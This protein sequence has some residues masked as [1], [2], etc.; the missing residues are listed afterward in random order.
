[1]NSKKEKIF[2]NSKR[3]FLFGRFALGL[4][5]TGFLL[6]YPSFN[7]LA[8]DGLM[9]GKFL[10]GET[11]DYLFWLQTY[12]S[13]TSPYYFDKFYINKAGNVGIGTTGPGYTL[14]VNGSINVASGSFYKYNGINLAYSQTA[15]NNYYF[16]ES[17]NL[18]G[19]GL[20]NTALGYRAL[21]NNT[22]GNQN[23]PIG[24][25][26]LYNNT[27]GN[28]NMAM[29]YYSLF[30]NTTGG[31]NV[32]LGSGSGYNGS[33]PLQ[34]MS[35]STFIGN[36]A[37][38]SVD[39]ITN[40]T[41]IGNGATVTASNQMV[42]G[43]SSVTQT[44][45]NGNVGIGTTAPG[46]KLDVSGTL[47]NTLAT[48]HSLLG[49]A[50]NAVVMADNTGTLYNTALSTFIS[51]NTLWGGTRNGNIW[52]GDAGVGNVGIGTTSPGA[53]LDVAGEIRITADG[54]G[55]ASNVAQIYTDA[56]NGLVITGHAGT[57]YDWAIADG[58]GTFQLVNPQGTSNLALVP[59]A[60]NVGIGTTAPGNKLQVQSFSNV[61][62]LSAENGVA[63]IGDAVSNV[64]LEIGSHN[65]APF[66]VWLQSK[67]PSNDGAFPL[68]LNPLGGN[69]G[70]GTVLPGAL[71]DV[72]GKVRV[73]GVNGLATANLNIQGNNVAGEEQLVIGNT[74]T[75]HWGA[76]F[77]STGNTDAFV[78]NNYNSDSARFDIRMK[79]TALADAKVTVLGSGNV[80]IGTTA[81][82]T[83]L[84]VSG[85]F[86]NTLAT[87]HSL[88]GGVGNAVV[89]AD[90]TGTL[91]NTALSTFISSNTLWGG[92]RNGNI[93][94]G[95]AGA[96]NVGIGTT[97]PTVK[98][99]VA[100]NSDANTNIANFLNGGQSTV[101][102]YTWISFGKS[103]ASG[104]AASFGFVEDTATPANSWA[105]FGTP[106]G[107]S[108]ATKSLIVA[109]SGNVGIGTTNPAQQLE[110]TKNFRI[111]STS[112][113]TPYGIIYKGT[114]PFIHDFNYGNNG[115][116][117][118]AGYNTF[119]GL[120][121]GNLTMGSTAT[122]TYHSSYNTAVGY[123]ALSSNTTGNYNTA[124]GYRSLYYN[125]TGF[126]NTANGM[127]SLYYN[128]TGYSNTANGF[129]SLYSN[130]TGYFNTAN[131]YLSLYS[132]TTGYNNTAL[133]LNSGRYIADGATGR[134]T[135][136]SGLY[137]G[138][139][140]K[141]SADGTD[142]EIV[143]G[144]SA[145]GK[146]T[147]TATYGN[148]SMTKHIFESGNVGIGTTG[149]GAKLDVSGTL[150]N[151]LATT[152]S[153]LGGVGNAVVMADNTGT[154]YNTALSTFISS[155]TLWGGTRNGNIWNGDAG[156]GN[157]GIGTT[158]PSY[159][160]DLGSPYTGIIGN[161]RLNGASSNL[162]REG[163]FEM[164][165]TI[166]GI[167]GISCWGGDAAVPSVINGDVPDGLN[168]IQYAQTHSSGGCQLWVNKNLIKV[169]PNQTYT[170]SFWAKLISGTVNSG[171]LMYIQS[172]DA[173]QS[174]I[175]ATGVYAGGNIST[176]WKRYSHS[177]TTGATTNYVRLFGYNYNTGVAQFD[178]VSFQKGDVSSEY[179]LSDSELAPD[180]V[181]Q[182][183]LFVNGNVGIGTTA[184]V[185]KLD[186]I[187]TTADADGEMRIG[188][189][190]NSDNLPFG[191]INFANTNAANT[192]T[193]DILSSIS[194]Y[195]KGSSNRGSIL[196]KTNEGSGLVDRMIVDEYGNVGIGTTAPGTKLDVSGTLRN[197]LATT[198]S[199]LGG[200]GNAVVM[201]DNTGTLYNTA[202]STFIS[203]NTLWGGTR[204]GNIWNG[205]AGVGNVGIGTTNPT[206]KL[207]VTGAIR[208]TGAITSEGG[209]NIGTGGGYNLLSYTG[210][211]FNI[212]GINDL[213]NSVALKTNQSTRL[214]IALAGNVGIGTTAPQTKLTIEDTSGT[215]RMRLNNGQNSWSVSNQNLGAFP[216]NSI[217]TFDVSGSYSPK[218]AIDASGNVGIGT[219]NPAQKLHVIGNGII[220]G[221]DGN[222]LS[223]RGN[224]ETSGLL[225]SSSASGYKEIQ[226]FESEPLYINRQGNN[227]ILN[228]TAGNVGIGTTAPGTK[229]DVTGTLR[230]TLATTHS[231]LGGV[232]NAVVMADNTG[233]LYN[234]AL[235]TFISSNTLWSGT[236]NGNIWNGD[237]GVGNVGIGTTSPTAPLH[238]KSDVATVISASTLDDTGMSGMR[239]SNYDTTA[240]AGGLLSFQ[241]GSSGTSWAGIGA[242]RPSADNSELAFFT[243]S[244]SVGERM[245]IT[246]T[247]NVG[248][249]TTNPAQQLEIT[250]NFRMPSTSG[251]TPYGIIYKGTTPFIHDFN[252]GNNGT[253]TTAGYNTFVG[254]GAGNLT[255]GSTATSA[256][257]SS[258]NTAVGYGALSS[259]TTGNYNTA[260]GYRSLYYNTTGFQNTANGMHSLNYNTTGHYN[261]ANGMYSLFYNTTGN[262][263]TANGY[264]S[265][266]SNTTGANNTALGF[267][268]ARYIADGATGRTTGN[269]GLYLGYDSK[270]SADGTDNEIVIGYNAI[271]KGSNTAT[272]GNTSMTKHI[273]ESG[274]VGIG[275]TTPGT[276]L[277]LDGTTENIVDVTG[278]K[279]VGLNTTPTGASEAVPLTYLQSNY[280]PLGSGAGSAYVQGGN[281]FGTTATLG[282][283]DNNLLN[284]ETNNAVRMTVAAGGNVG[285]GTTNPNSLLDVSA[286]ISGKA[287]LTLQADTDNNNEL[288]NP[289]IHF[290]QD[291][292]LVTGTLGLVGGNNL[293]SMGSAYTGASDNG[294][295]IASYHSSY[296]LQLG[297]GSAV[298]MTIA[299]NGNIGIGTTGPTHKLEVVGDI[300]AGTGV[301]DFK[302]TGVPAT[303]GNFN[304]GQTSGSGKINFVSN[305]DISLVTI[306]NNGNV[307]IGTTT[308][309]TKLTLDGTTGNIVDVTGG[310][311]VGLNTTPTGASE[312]VPLT[313]LQSNYTPIGSGAG[314]IG[315]G[316]T[317]QTLRHNGTS[318]IANSVIFNNGTNVGI[319][320][321]AP[322]RLL[323]VNGT[324]HAVGL[325][326][327][328]SNLVFTQ[329][330]SARNIGVVGT[331]SPNSLAAIWSMGAA[332]QLTATGTAGNLYG[333][334]YSYEPDYGG[335]GNNPGAIA[336][337]EHQIQW[338]ANGVTKTAI[339]TG[340]YTVGNVS[341]AGTTGLTLS[342]AGADLNFTGTGPNLVNTASGVNLALMPGGAGNVGIGTTAPSQKMHV[343]GNIKTSGD[344]ITDGNYGLG[345]VGLYSATRYQNVFA[346]GTSYRLA[347]DGTTPGNLYGIAWTHS[348]ISGQS[349]SGLAHQALFMNNGVTQTAIGTGIWTLGGYTQNGTS[350]NSFSGNV[351]IGT[352]SPGTKLSITGAYP[353][354]QI[355][356]VEDEGLFFAGASAASHYNWLIGEQ[357][358]VSSALEITPSTVVGGTTFS[359]PT[360]VFTQTGNV[361]IGTTI[362]VSRLNISE[363]TG[364]VYGAVQGSV[365]IDHENSGG[366]SSIVF[367]SRVNRGSD[368]GFIQ[369]QDTATVGGAGETAKL[370]IGTSNDTNDDIALMPTGNV[371]I[372]TTNPTAKLDF[373]TSGAASNVI[374]TY[375]SGNIIQGIGND[376]YGM[377]IFYPSSSAGNLAIGTV[378]TADGV[379]WSEK[380]R[381][382]NL[383][384][385]GIG[386]TN[387]LEK[388][389]V[390]GASNATD[391]EWAAA[392][393]NPNNTISG[394]Y[395]VGLKLRNGDVSEPGK[396]SGIAAVAESG[397]SNLTGLALYAN[398]TEKVRIMNNGNVGIGTTNPG[399][400]LEI[401][402]GVRE[403]SLSGNS[404]LDIV[405]TAIASRTTN[406]VQNLLRLHQPN[407]ALSDS[408]G[409]T[410]AI[411]ISFPDDPGNNYPRTRVDFKTTGRTTDDAD[412]GNTVMSLMDSGNVG[413]GTTAPGTGVTMTGG[414]DVNGT[415]ST[416]FIVRKNGGFGLALNVNANYSW[417]MYDGYGSSWK[418]GIT[419]QN[420]NVGIG[421]TNPASK[422]EVLGT[423]TVSTVA[424]DGLGM[425]KAGTFDPPYTIDGVKY[426]TYL[427]SMTGV[428]EETTGTTKLVGIGKSGLYKKRL[429]MLEATPGSDLWLFSRVTDIKN[430]GLDDLTVLLSP[431]FEGTTWYEKD[432]A[433]GAITIYARPKGQNII[434]EVS[435]RLTAPR[436][437]NGEFKNQRSVYDP[438]EGFNLDK[439]IK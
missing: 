173:S 422:L 218:M 406:T 28:Q 340:I 359:T 236:R 305:A 230:N 317:G 75:Y 390:Q 255:M 69:V 385:V 411:G 356:S 224:T 194:G 7:A 147:N 135:G 281:S 51:S 221:N 349:K 107:N 208:T 22:T 438:V 314:G 111:P 373:G 57:T 100:S 178:G 23:N 372:G 160:L 129:L 400:S 334:N 310:R 79:G 80:G 368:Y 324:F 304:I 70:I 272:Y 13:A 110:I 298:R 439:L 225:L 106:Y 66:G 329:S 149:P 249:G 309:G 148:T 201:A 171:N 89:M 251:T 3:F 183:S 353:Q 128:T 24:Y 97:A 244:G 226:S 60:G 191:T 91:Y 116:V 252:Y 327:L 423:L 274:N 15:L 158:N 250:K 282:T 266:Y 215:V 273:F 206:Y 424:G 307:G 90:N 8:I 32:A 140:S 76:G 336:G 217:L 120:G 267:Y 39:G 141:A 83:K 72:A 331:Y 143:I 427:P 63:I 395:G 297:A 126:N 162:F 38:S 270:A 220:G 335:A 292:A 306:L 200:V 53:K 253:V 179:A 300:Y 346:M 19:T 86:R 428:K 295:L 375:T 358:N 125:T 114:T 31:Y 404:V 103:L 437:D 401:A 357:Y 389:Y 20:Q 9:N 188:G 54:G 394:S 113:T 195:K 196:F 181:A 237:A 354:I 388:L 41:A 133:G 187:E 320:T 408:K 278:G 379:T 210:S 269:N 362:P 176:T 348:N 392:L 118:T 279:I 78:S 2:L 416:Q 155:N 132:N 363:A 315:T 144:A 239:I 351:G 163:S 50:G 301:G 43:N 58:G 166:Y 48:T 165:G 333:L 425:I 47:R 46:T 18:T 172:Y 56:T 42:F 40:S 276:K 414:L 318:W 4:V 101:G 383:G 150:R 84:D 71:L 376:G 131:G 185:K 193:D 96:G 29:G 108:E 259:N 138:Y 285:I 157:V 198:H 248:I 434:P 11:D 377:R 92:T 52:N 6:F 35:Y 299:G 167:S 323:D 286:G 134:T 168:A 104:G 197:T 82:G 337:L 64:G 87:T 258:Y 345:L 433:R 312:A 341:L 421:L 37:K 189:L 152:H 380:V 261:T 211:T 154:L 55:F 397:W 430:K 145:I 412:A 322:G 112:G 209:Y 242:L 303:G 313:Y 235:S 234:T 227:L 374:R 182:G 153:L 228:A 265:L 14:D 344:I 26:S 391:I 229:L 289:F 12:D 378:S 402:K 94:N 222:Y 288:D 293:D 95:D 264:A 338:R 85:S 190:L 121:A 238:I 284:I 325:S 296:P 44:L 177:F 436:F 245:R 294:L 271:G 161:A 117:T 180:A 130:T 339:G 77:N 136:N 16:G 33:V 410:F 435:Y 399:V 233:T 232:G 219:T 280:A 302:L 174:V 73:G 59:T 156:A 202:L 65:A 81:P 352:V 370:I 186:V 212:G 431:H 415:G 268:S 231:L 246:S 45:L 137:L 223:I 262:Y 192:Q 342:G 27:T 409:S 68:Y 159:K 213:V 328:D 418:A 287:G 290:K 277:T 98:F 169:Q 369:Y 343:V 361:G 291:G 205:D 381:I 316:T 420:G 216:L 175:G 115:T 330:S 403:T 102:R 151:T 263:N 419:Q 25:Q 382:N 365:V 417:T 321:T 347:A 364:T 384:N 241:L 355:G 170:Y 350:V 393:K 387:P 5:I 360:A 386:T 426:A 142:N 283:N 214:F 398:A 371:G 247:G 30:N 99:D 407:T 49:G 61:P 413:I 396:W 124:N 432:E 243:E 204:N 74:A 308:P 164:Y 275:T 207:D 256:A 62:S 146:G 123:G 88:L 367:R 36:V 122:Q 326:T 257:H 17:G 93:W 127:Y 203:S 67:K 311:I 366:A 240:N 199:L 119:V 10:T 34:T 1:M 319:G 405:G 260:N 332:Y 429:E 21:Y 109:N 105:Y 139:N 254:L 184:P